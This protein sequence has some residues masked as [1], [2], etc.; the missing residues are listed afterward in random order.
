MRIV[1]CLTCPATRSAHPRKFN[2]RPADDFVALHNTTIPCVD[3]DVEPLQVCSQVVAG[4]NYEVL[5]HITCENSATA[6][7]TVYGE[8]F[9]PLP[10]AA[11]QGIVVSEVEPIT[12]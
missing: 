4:T 6:P 11:T 8:A 7:V 1:P 12:E 10:S 3:Y 5:L 9:V 2:F